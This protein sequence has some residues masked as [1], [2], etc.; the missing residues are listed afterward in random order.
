LYFTKEDCIK[1]ILDF[2]SGL[3]GK[4]LTRDFYRKNSTIPENVWI[5][6]FGTFKELQRAAKI[7]PSLFSNQL[8]NA[9][10]KHSS[11]DNVKK[12]NE[13]KSLWEGNYLRPSGKR[14]QT[15]VVCSDLHDIN[16][17]PF[18]YRTFIDTISRINPEKIILNGDIFDMTEFSKYSV[19]PREYDIIKRIKWVHGFLENI[20]NVCPY[21]E[22]NFIEGNHEFRLLRNLSESNPGLQIILSDLHGFTIHKLLG[23]EEFEINYYARADLKAFNK[24]DINNEL[25]KNYVIINDQVLFHH[26]PTGKDFGYPGAHAH[27]H[28]HLVWNSVNPIFGS[29]EWHQ[30]GCGH[31]RQASYTPGEKW[32]NGFLIA[33]LDTHKKK[34]QFE[35]VDTTHD[36]CVIGGKFYFRTEKELE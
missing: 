12:I 11:L 26:F 17:D 34:T 8:N 27:H 35:Y 28:K 23:L 2:H 18:F 1:D 25:S 3:E 22:I 7:V 24:T 13:E 29:F 10:A 21:T 15:I 14:F 33:H 31:K 6:Y 5:K 32:S 30:L 36:H 4:V 16:C 9:V 19:D 20:R